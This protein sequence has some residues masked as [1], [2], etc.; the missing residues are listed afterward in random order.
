MS[1]NSFYLVV[2]DNPT[3]RTIASI[4]LKKCLNNPEVHLEEDSDN[5]IEWIRENRSSISKKLVIL[6][7]MLMPNVDGF[8]FLEAYDRL[9]ETSKSRSEIIM[10]SSMDEVSDFTF[11]AKNHPLVKCVLPKP[12]NI[13]VLK[14]V[15]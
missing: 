10:L 11:K 7:D 15:V 12:L 4:L 8:G 2:D 14:E 1:D 5:A 9:D 3:D 13:D 6:L